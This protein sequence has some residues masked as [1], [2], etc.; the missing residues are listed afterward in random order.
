MKKVLLIGQLNQTVSSV[1]RHLAT[2]FEVQLSTDGL[3]AVKGMTEI[4]EPDLVI[5]SLIGLGKLDEAVLD[6]FKN[7]YPQIPVLLLGTLE[8]C[9]YYHDYYESRQFDYA[10]RPLTLSIFMQK[11]LT[12]L[13]MGNDGAVE[14]ENLLEKDG[15]R[16]HIL[17][18]DDSGVLLRSVKV[19]LEKNYDVSFATSGQ[20]ALKQ[21]KKQ[22]PDLIL[23]DYEMPGWDGKKTLEEIQADEELKDIPVVFLTGVADKNHILAVL[24]LN[25]AG[26]LLKP[27]ER[28]R[29]LDTIYNVLAGVV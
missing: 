26:Y 19:I 22:K 8:E 17:V 6:F 16:R 29:L 9:N 18:V 1:K 2:R 28:E 15:R 12:I 27:I 11:C 20:M 23:L 5:A 4:F 13:R 21:A 14:Y 25:P 10:V 7:D 24:K 3:D